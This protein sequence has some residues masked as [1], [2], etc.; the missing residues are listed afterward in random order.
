MITV[1]QVLGMSLSITSNFVTMRR[2]S[3]LLGKRSTFSTSVCVCVCVRNSASQLSL[4][5]IAVL[6]SPTYSHTLPPFYLHASPSHYLYLSLSLSLRPSFSHLTETEEWQNRRV[7][8][9]ASEKPKERGA[10]YNRKKDLL[11][12]EGVKE[13]WMHILPT[14]ISLTQCWLCSSSFLSWHHKSSLTDLI[15]INLNPSVVNGDGFTCLETAHEC[16][17]KRK[18][19]SCLSRLTYFSANSSSIT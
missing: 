6:P 4:P 11:R 15:I 13:M 7:M 18:E 10:F 8:E 12:T 19:A 2:S 14:V 17:L 3:S 16:H 5:Q 9:R 1:I